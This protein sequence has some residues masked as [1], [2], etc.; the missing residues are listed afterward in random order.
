M[1]T[2]FRAGV[3]AVFIA[4]AASTLSS[5]E[6]LPSAVQSAI[7][8]YKFSR[9]DVAI[10]IKQTGKNRVVASLNIDKEM[11]PASVIKVYSTYAALLE[12]G[13]DYRWPTKFYSTGKL[14]NGILYGDLV[15]K[16]FGDPTLRTADIAPIVS[17]LKAKGIRKI[18][19][20]IIWFNGYKF[21]FWLSRPI[22][23]KIK[24]I[25]IKRDNVGDFYICVAIEKEYQKFNITS[26]KIVGIDFGLK[27]F[28]T[29][30]DGKQI[31]SPRYYLNYLKELRKLQKKLS[32]KIQNSNNYKQ[33]KRKIAKLYQK[34]VNSRKDFFL[35]PKVGMTGGTFYGN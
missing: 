31:N 5:A 1:S 11:L 20:N 14:K 24:T 27:T 16:G 2:F 15:V 3:I 17:A 10:Y 13:Y 26:G 12:L 4:L 28:L 35:P 29:L 21:K 32:K 7:K 22:E 25:T 6:I 8:R 33:A 9:N 19:G 34:V 30:S 23:G 18:E